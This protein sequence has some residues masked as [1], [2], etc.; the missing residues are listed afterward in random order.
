MCHPHRYHCVP[1]RPNDGLEEHV[2][3]FGEESIFVSV[4]ECK[5]PKNMLH[6]RNTPRTAT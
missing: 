1:G 6:I 5:V 2:F 4:I 3:Q